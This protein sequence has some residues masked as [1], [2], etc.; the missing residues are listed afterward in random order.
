MAW[1]DAGLFSGARHLM[2]F[3]ESDPRKAEGSARVAIWTGTDVDTDLVVIDAVRRIPVA[4]R[5]LHELASQ[6]SGRAN[7]GVVGYSDSM[8]SRIPG[9]CPYQLF[10]GTC[11]GRT[12]KNGGA[13]CVA[14][15]DAENWAPKM[16]DGISRDSE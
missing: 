12:I 9:L 8:A 5:W 15:I 7:V 11:V 14:I 6:H 2:V 10:L 1:Y 4:V 13:K 16:G 3:S